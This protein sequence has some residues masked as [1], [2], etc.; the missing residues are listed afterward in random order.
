MLANFGK[1]LRMARQFIISHT[2]T[3]NLVW[4]KPGTDTG[5]SNPMRHSGVQHGL[6]GTDEGR[7]F[8]SVLAVLYTPKEYGGSRLS[9]AF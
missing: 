3:F 6:V 7:L 2:L 8:E 4:T 5:H 9:W 1:I